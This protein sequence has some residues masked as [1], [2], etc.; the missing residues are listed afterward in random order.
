M[1]RIIKTETKTNIGLKIVNEYVNGTSSSVDFFKD[2]LVEDLDYVKDSAVV[3]ATGRLESIGAEIIPNQK[4][5][6]DRLTDPIADRLKLNTVK[7]DMSTSMYANQVEIPTQEILEYKAVIE[8]KRVKIMPIMEVDIKVTLSDG[9]VTATTLREGAEYNDV[10]LL[11]PDGDN[12]MDFIIGAFV[13]SID[14]E[15][16]DVNVIGLQTSGMS[17]TIIELMAIKHCGE[18]TEVDDTSGDDEPGCTCTCPGCTN[19]P[20]DPENPDPDKDPDSGKEDPQPPVDGCTCTCP[21]CTNKPTD[22]ENPDPDKDP[23]SG[24]EP[25]DKDPKPQPPVEPEK[26]Y[27]VTLSTVTG[28]TVISNVQEAKAGEEVT[29]TL[30]S[31]PGYRLNVNNIV[32]DAAGTA[33]TTTAT[34]GLDTFKFTMPKDGVTVTPVFEKIFVVDS[35]PVPVAKFTGAAKRFS[36]TFYNQLTE[37]MNFDSDTNQLVS[38]TTGAPVSGK[39]LDDDNWWFTITDG[40]KIKADELTSI[41]SVDTATELSKEPVKISVGNSKRITCP[42]YIIDENGDIK[43]SYAFVALTASTTGK[44]EFFM[45]FA[46]HTSASAVLDVAPLE[47]SLKCS[48][49]QI[50]TGFTED[51]MQISMSKNSDNTEINFTTK[52]T[53][54]ASNWSG[55]MF[56][57]SLINEAEGL[58]QEENPIYY[59]TKK[60]WDGSKVEYGFSRNEDME[61]D[62]TAL[63]FYPIGLTA[64]T[65]Y[66]DCVYEIATAQRHGVVKMHF[67]IKYAAGTRK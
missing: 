64:A 35:A 24:E 54:D 10:K 34:D 57:I 21:G 65:Q 1:A 49:I 26:A 28:G 29:L 55:K 59:V 14:P 31:N 30:T 4:K 25:D 44:L 47:N 58:S 53:F 51:S 46:D 2:D 23:D 16:L 39:E 36:D 33:V 48:D 15:T 63:G 66:D 27:P 43:I 50:P 13:Y 38:A 7:L 61:V 40:G 45:T 6:Y 19:K 60:T 67:S 32:K 62:K 56:L 8:T 5:K 37:N 12:K 17:S 3:S 20:T 18:G 9:T 41:A 11:G 52:S 22:P 42:D